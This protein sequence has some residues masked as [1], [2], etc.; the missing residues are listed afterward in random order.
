MPADHEGERRGVFRI[1]VAAA[2]VDVKMGKLEG[3]ELL[4]ANSEGIGVIIPADCPLPAIGD[5]LSVA[6]EWSGQRFEGFMVV[7]NLW[8]REGGGYRC[9]LQTVPTEWAL[10]RGLRRLAIDAQRRQLRLRAQR[11]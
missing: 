3:C 9:G 1:C 6:F 5:V 11:K 10:R 4:D 2:F 8:P 7:R